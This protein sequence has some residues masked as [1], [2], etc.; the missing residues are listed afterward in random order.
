M[1][2][3][4]FFLP[5]AACPGRCVYCNQ[6]KIT[7]QE[8]IPSPSFV[9]S[10]LEQQQEAKE[11]CF[12]G[13]S[14]LRFPFET[15]KTY[16][17]T[18]K[19]F[20]PKGSSVRF[21][22]YPND[23]DDENI[24]GL[25]KNYSI[26]RIELGIQSLD[27][28]VLKNCKRDLDPALILKSVAH[29]AHHGFPLGMQLMIGLP[30]QTEESSLDDLNKL[31]KIKA[32][33]V[34]DLRIYPCLVIEDTELAQMY[35]EGSYKPLSVEQAVYTSGKLL[36]EAEKLGFNVIRI[37]LQESGSLADSVIAGPHHPALGELAMSY[38]LV[39]K[40]T[41]LKPN[42]PWQLQKKELSKFSGHNEFG[43]KLLAEA[44]KKSLDEIKTLIHF[45]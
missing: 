37:G 4:P 7:G 13:G 18:V 9:R 28:T 3:L 45:L 27:K 31:A 21:S 14:F 39:N 12:F 36:V 16:L 20:A 23:L 32:G 11:V 19:E 24:C 10:V 38:A 25:L 22:T 1:N 2:K 44:T 17:D 43:Y 8:K 15:V 5:F 42:G 33:A 30:G 26:S 40:L 29:A 35:K 34:W 6:N 41:K